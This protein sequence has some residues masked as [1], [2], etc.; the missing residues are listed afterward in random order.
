M[1]QMALFFSNKYFFVSRKY[2]VAKTLV[3]KYETWKLFFQQSFYFIIV[4]FLS[5]A[6]KLKKFLYF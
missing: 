3:Q 4:N 2:T 5:I 1:N 6:S